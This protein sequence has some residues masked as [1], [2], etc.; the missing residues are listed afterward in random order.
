MHLLQ[1][2]TTVDGIPV[3]PHAWEA[4]Q[5]L[6]SLGIK[7]KLASGLVSLNFAGMLSA[8]VVLLWAAELWKFGGTLKKKQRTTG[9]LNT[10][11]DALSHGDYLTATTNYERALEIDRNP[12]I[13]MALGQVYAQ[14]QNSRFK[15][16]RIFEGAVTLLADQPGRTMP[17]HQMQ[18]SVRGFAGI[19]ALSTVDVFEGLPQDYWNDYLSKLVQATCYSFQAAAQSQAKQSSD[20]IPDAVVNPA[21]FSAA[22]NYYLAAKAA[23]YYPFLNEQEELIS[24]NLEAARQALGLVGQ[25]DEEVLRPSVET[26]RTL[27]TYELLPD[28]G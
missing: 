22:I 20:R 13:M 16:H 21:L 27:W 1:D 15:S 2:F 18:I 17:Y 7:P 5:V 6:Q 9:F 14:H 3:L 11:V 25:Y 24:K 12:Y 28:D 19:Q 10:A 8:M 26:L 4:K 23:C